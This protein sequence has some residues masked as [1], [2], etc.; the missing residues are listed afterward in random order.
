MSAV[1]IQSTDVSRERCWFGAEIFDLAN[2][3][4]K[5]DGHCVS[6]TREYRTNAL[7]R[8]NASLFAKC[9]GGE[10]GNSSNQPVA[11]DR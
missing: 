1:R 5:D 8:L 10:P 11:T 3:V 7:D 4:R 2:V 6:Q 9:S